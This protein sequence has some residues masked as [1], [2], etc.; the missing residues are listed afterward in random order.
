MVLVKW[1]EYS[2]K[3]TTWE[4]TTNIPDAVLNKMNERNR[5]QL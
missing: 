5:L 3:H 2:A 1:K 4:L